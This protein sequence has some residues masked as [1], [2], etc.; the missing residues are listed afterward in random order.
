M[1]QANNVDAA[2]L[3]KVLLFET[4][5]YT[6]TSNQRTNCKSICFLEELQSPTKLVVE[7]GL[8]LRRHASVETFKLTLLEQLRSGDDGSRTLEVDSSEWI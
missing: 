5:H 4:R 8:S 2:V 3:G 7:L 6:P 1:R